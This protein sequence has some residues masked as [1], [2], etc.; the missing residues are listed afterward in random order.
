MKKCSMCK[1]VKEDREFTKRAGTASG[2]GCRCTPCRTVY[3]ESRKDK[4]KNYQKLNAKT[5]ADKKRDYYLRNKISILENKRAYYES[6]KVSILQHIKSN[7]QII[8]DRV[9]KKNKE[10]PVRA[11][12]KNLKARLSYAARTMGTTSPGGKRLR[13][14]R[15]KL[16]L[17]IE[18]NFK[19]GMSWENY[20]EWHIDHVKPI[21]AFVAKGHDL[22][23]VNLLCNL[24]PEWAEDNRRKSSTFKGAYFRLPGGDNAAQGVQ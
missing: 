20:G 5:I 10:E 7:R 13:A 16:R 18:T 12:V 21:A 23:L 9:N 3:N 24:R 1:I 2:L 4:R 6:N 11:I 22:K 19:P 8:N 14:E 15:E 17:R